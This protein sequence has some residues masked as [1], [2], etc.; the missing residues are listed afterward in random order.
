MRFVS[1]VGSVA[2]VVR[3]ILMVVGKR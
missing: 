3:T 1:I 2:A